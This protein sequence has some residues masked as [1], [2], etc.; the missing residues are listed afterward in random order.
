[1]AGGG[2]GALHGS[3]GIGVM[4]VPV[5]HGGGMRGLRCLV[6][7][8]RGA[9]GILS[10]HDSYHSYDSHAHPRRPFAAVRRP[11]MGIGVMGVMGVPVAHGGG[12]RGL[13]CLVSGIRGAPG[14]L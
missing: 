8:I 10:S 1:M 3:H 6:S 4:G 14:F 13:R 12:M 11:C 9:P 7:G 5:A 2:V